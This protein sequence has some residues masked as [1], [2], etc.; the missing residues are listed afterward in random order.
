MHFTLGMDGS[1]PN[2]VYKSKEDDF[3]PGDSSDSEDE[4]SFTIPLPGEIEVISP[5]KPSQQTEQEN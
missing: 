4:S 3:K 5:T 1:G 2:I